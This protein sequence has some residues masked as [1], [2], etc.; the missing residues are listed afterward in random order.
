MKY[1]VEELKQIIDL[2][3]LNQIEQFK[4]DDIHIVK[5]R[6]PVPKPEPKS[7]NDATFNDEVDDLIFHSTS[8]PALT[9]EQLASLTT[10]PL[11]AKAK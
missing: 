10:T 3:M 11:K 2:V 1:S 4:V 9:L 8:A 5:N 7:N 6:Y